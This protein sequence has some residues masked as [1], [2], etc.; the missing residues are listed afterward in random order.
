M[1]LYV[2]CVHCGGDGTKLVDLPCGCC[3]SM[4]DCDEC[5]GEGY[6]EYEPE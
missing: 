2:K 3:I 4:D 1:Q 5:D 6:V